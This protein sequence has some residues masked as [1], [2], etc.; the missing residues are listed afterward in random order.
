MTE[1][2]QCGVALPAG[3]AKMR[4]VQVATAKSRSFSMRGRIRWGASK[5][6][7]RRRFCEICAKSID[8]RKRIKFGIAFVLLGV[9]IYYAKSHGFLD[10][11]TQQS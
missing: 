1:C 7:A 2:Y 6:Y 9:G 5:A 11:L 3:Q 10:S 8:T 4:K